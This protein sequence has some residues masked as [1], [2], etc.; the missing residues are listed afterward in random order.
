MSAPEPALPNDPAEPRPRPLMGAGFWAL[1]VFGL[2]FVLAGVGVT[3]MGPRWLPAK[4]QAAISS[5]PDAPAPAA[6]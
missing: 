2:L 6:P 5:T 1:V 4:P 3:L